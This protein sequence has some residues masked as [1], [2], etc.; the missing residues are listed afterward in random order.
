MLSC[1]GRFPPKTCPIDEPF[2]P[3]LPVVNSYLRNL[4]I[5]GTLKQKLKSIKKNVNE[6]KLYDFSLMSVSVLAPLRSS[7][8][9]DLRISSSCPSS[10][11]RLAEI[12]KSDS[13][14]EFAWTLIF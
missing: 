12:S 9:F 8:V 13:K 6:D 2:S 14:R 1:L 11:C 7:P 10:I 4:T 3:V 5:Q